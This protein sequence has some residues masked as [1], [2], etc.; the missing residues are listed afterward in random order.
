MRRQKVSINLI[1]SRAADETTNEHSQRIALETNTIDDSYES[2][3]RGKLPNH[4]SFIVCPGKHPIKIASN[5][6]VS[7]H[8]YFDNFVR[9]KPKD[10]PQHDGIYLHITDEGF[11]DNNNYHNQ[12][13]NESNHANNRVNAYHKS[14]KSHNGEGHANKGPEIRIIE[15]NRDIKS[16]NRA[17][18]SVKHSVWIHSMISGKQSD[19]SVERSIEN[20]LRALSEK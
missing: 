6:G 15:S 16:I 5:H 20:R 18:G 9:R 1:E 11:H 2:Q 7:I 17:D 8:I 3:Q 19:D 12:S 13:N 4:E 14:S 10:A